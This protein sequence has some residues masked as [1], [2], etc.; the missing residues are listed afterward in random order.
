MIAVWR[1][2]FPCP[3]I[4]CLRHRKALTTSSNHNY[5]T[6]CSASKW[7]LL[8]TALPLSTTDFHKVFIKH[9]STWRGVNRNRNLLFQTGRSNR[10]QPVWMVSTASNF[11]LINNPGRLICRRSPKKGGC[12]HFWHLS[13]GSRRNLL[14]QR[15]KCRLLC[16]RSHIQRRKNGLSTTMPTLLA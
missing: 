9:G 5:Y 3:R 7:G 15:E 13:K 2:R 4:N 1:K 10:H 16:T 6:C 11:W 14:A 12:R 8:M